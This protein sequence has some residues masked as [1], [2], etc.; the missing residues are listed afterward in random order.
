MPLRRVAP[1]I[2]HVLGLRF[3]PDQKPSIGRIVHYRPPEGIN[4]GPANVRPAIVVNVFGEGTIVNLH[5][6]TDPINDTPLAAEH[7]CSVDFSEESKARS[8]CWPPRV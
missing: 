2:I 3:M 1:G 7:Q 6:F 5:V 8:W 4:G